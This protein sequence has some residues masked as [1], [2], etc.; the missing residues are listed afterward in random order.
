M[1]A[2]QTETRTHRLALAVSLIAI[3]TILVPLAHSDPPD[4]TWFPGVW[5]DA[6]YDDVVTLATSSSSIADAY[7]PT[8]FD[9]LVI[10][11]RIRD[12]EASVLA[13]R[14]L[15]LNSRAPPLA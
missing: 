7:V 12:S 11:G 8:S 14:L 2:A 3:L 5:D 6:D 15:A 1:F 13:V 10:V 4:P 9:F